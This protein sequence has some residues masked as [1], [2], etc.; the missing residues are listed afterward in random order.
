MTVLLALC[1]VV[2]GVVVAAA[3]TVR[4]ADFGAATPPDRCVTATTGLSLALSALLIFPGE[5]CELEPVEAEWPLDDPVS[6]DATAAPPTM[7]APTPSVTAPAFNHIRML[8]AR[9]VPGVHAATD[10][11]RLIVLDA[12]VA[13]DANG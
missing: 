2:D 10:Y 8:Y 13:G 5:V 4:A 7:A 12:P 9:R 6:A 11:P 3:A 1:D